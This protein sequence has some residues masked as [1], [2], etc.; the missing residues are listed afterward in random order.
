MFWSPA[1]E[2]QP[3]SQLTWFGGC[4]VSG[5]SIRALDYPLMIDINAAVKG[6]GSRS[7]RMAS[8]WL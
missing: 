3:L 8:C 6:V 1:H 4:L 2:C 5:G 7:P